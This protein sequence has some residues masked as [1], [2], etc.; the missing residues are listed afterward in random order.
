MSV[1]ERPEIVADCE[2]TLPYPSTTCSNI[3]ECD[4][5]ALIVVIMS[6]FIRANFTCKCF[7]GY[8]IVDAYS[9]TYT[10]FVIY[11]HVPTYW[12]YLCKLYQGKRSHKLGVL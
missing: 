5:S 7:S 12:N 11:S 8:E 4:N 6:E 10:W 1:L 2:L 3:N 9:Q